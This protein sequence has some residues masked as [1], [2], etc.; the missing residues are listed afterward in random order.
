M[1]I[2]AYQIS[3]ERDD[4][5]SKNK[6]FGGSNERAVALNR[7]EHKLRVIMRRAIRKALKDEGV[8]HYVRYGEIIIKE[9][10]LEDELWEHHFTIDAYANH[11]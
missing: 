7:Y 3:T 6:R 9:Q 1:L 4:T 2:Y 10:H 5:M 11:I 8:D